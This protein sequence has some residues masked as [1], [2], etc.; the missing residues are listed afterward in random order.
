MRQLGKTHAILAI[1]LGIVLARSAVLVFWEQSF[2]DSNQA[3]I[4]LMAKHLL[5]LRAFPVF[6]YGQNYMLAVESWLAAPV[7][8][9]A[10]MSPATLKL[11]LLAMNGLVAVLFL[12]LL[13]RENRLSPALAAVATLFFVLPPPGTAA[14][15]LEASGGNI[16]PF[17]YILL[18]WM[19]R[20]R[21]VLCGMILGFGVRHREFTV[22]G[23]VSL[24]VIDALR[25][26]LGKVQL[27]RWAVTVSCATAIWVVI[28]VVGQYGSA[29][30]P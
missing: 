27:K 12:R 2:F 5:E 28:Q 22:Y 16:E 25:G 11:P 1:I 19:T 20:H 9:V 4:G 7:F 15:L 8:L 30:G 18:L 29:M 21:P 10:G 6:M 14:Q 17:L 26:P 23:F 3:V 24:L 13:Q